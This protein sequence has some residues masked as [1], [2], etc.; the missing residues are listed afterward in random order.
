MR[1]KIQKL[2]GVFPV[3]LDKAVYITGTK[4]K[5][6][7]KLNE[8]TEITSKGYKIYNI[9]D[10]GAK[11]DGINDDGK[12]IIATINELPEEKFCLYIPS[13]IYMHG[14]GTYNTMNYEV[15]PDGPISEPNLGIPNFFLFENKHD[16]IILGTKD[17]LIK[18]HP[19]N[20]CIINNRPFDFKYCNNF[21]VREIHYDGNIEARQPSMKDYTQINR[22]SGITIDACQNFKIVDSSFNNTCMDGIF[23]GSQIGNEILNE[24]KNVLTDGGIIK[25]VQC[26]YN[27]RQGMSVVNARNLVIES[28]EFSYTGTKYYTSPGAGIDFE[29]GY[30]K[31]LRGQINITVRGCKA[32]NNKGGGI[33]PHWGTSNFIMERCYLENNM[34]SAPTDSEAMTVNHTYRDNIFVNCGIDSD[35]GGEHII[36]N[37]FILNDDKTANAINIADSKKWTE[38]GRCRQPVISGNVIKCDPTAAMAKENGKIGQIWSYGVP[39][40]IFDNNIIENAYSTNMGLYDS[41]EIAS[42]KN[43]TIIWDHD[44]VTNTNSFIINDVREMSGNKVVGPVKNNIDKVEKAIGQSMNTIEK[45][46]ELQDLTQNKAIDI[47][48][49]GQ[50]ISL[51]LIYH[52]AYPI[53]R[54]R[55]EVFNFGFFGD[56]RKKELLYQLEDGTMF[57]RSSQ[58]YKKDD[59]VFITL[60]NLNTEPQTTQISVRAFCRD[61]STNDRITFSNIYSYDNNTNLDFKLSYNRMEGESNPNIED[62]NLKVGDTFYNTTDKIIY[63]FNGKDW[64][65]ERFFNNYSEIE[66]D[67]IMEVEP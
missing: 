4:K 31:P 2:T 46:K 57:I 65:D 59:A 51:E 45:S 28:S 49:T 47:K 39:D 25:N 66:P 19:N 33:L 55:K 6:D 41:K 36:N 56:P 61:R 43:N 53:Q 20:G 60:C 9:K 8:L 29:E 13:G 38:L 10:Y 58:A 63:K 42:C 26:N 32:I 23:I 30:E 22:Q 54:V 37:T 67:E 62:Y 3:T 21:E 44:E 35:A 24:K 5:L 48:I 14:D 64:I 1:A 16:F 11:G 17:S 52:D 15:G 34:V 12:A 18:A 27:Y 7:E 50:V 40:L